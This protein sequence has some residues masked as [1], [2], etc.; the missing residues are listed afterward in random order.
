MIIRKNL[1]YTYT[2]RIRYIH[3]VVFFILLDLT[4]FYFFRRNKT[5]NK[6]LTHKHQQNPRYTRHDTILFLYLYKILHYKIFKKYILTFFMH[7]YQ[8]IFRRNRKLKQKVYQVNLW[9]LRYILTLKHSGFIS[10][11]LHL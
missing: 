10:V 3:H 8:I 11:T 9:I 7:T 4:R 1:R 6:K 2:I 5:Q